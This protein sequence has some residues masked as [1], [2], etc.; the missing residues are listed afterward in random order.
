[1][2]EELLD[3]LEADRYVLLLFL[4]RIMPGESK[5]RVFESLLLRQY[6]SNGILQHLI[7]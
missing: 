2:T 1:M 5:D 6:I 3:E 7:E 4:F